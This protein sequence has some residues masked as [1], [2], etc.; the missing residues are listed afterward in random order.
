MWVLLGGVLFTHFG[1]YMIV[2]YFALYLAG[3]KH[4]PL[5]HVGLVLGAGSV[6]YLTGSLAGGFLADALGRKRTMVGGLLLRGAGL[7]LLLYMNTLYTL[8]LANL[9]A[10]FGNGLYS[11]TAKAGIALLAAEGTKTTAFSYR[12]IAANVGVTLGPLLGTTLHALSSRLLFAGAALVYV[13]LALAHLLVLERD[14]RPGVG[15]CPQRERVGFGDI[16]RDSPFL[17]FSLATIF[18]WVL[19]TQFALSLPLRAQQ[20]GA[21]GGVGV[22]WTVTAVFLILLQTTATRFATRFLHPLQAMALGTGVLG[23]AL[24]TVAFSSAYWHLVLSGILFTFGQML[25]MPTSDAIVSDLAG[26]QKVSAYFGISAIVF[27]AGET[28]GNIGGGQLMDYAVRH[29]VLS[30]PWLIY[31]FIGVAVGGLYYLLTFWQGLARQLAPALA[32]R[33]GTNGAKGS[34]SK[35]GT[36]R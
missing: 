15:D 18:V 6:A 1:T 2:P 21:A 12:G 9:V 30:L 29:D 7:F 8:L 34:G 26:A 4:L 3:T 5:V 31:G 13:L 25:V 32:E 22:I 23:I 33:A 10:G 20:I 27:G 11:P 17:A 14:C 19:F 36:V 35:K 28:L 24:A 16:F